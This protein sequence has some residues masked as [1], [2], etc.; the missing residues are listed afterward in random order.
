MCRCSPQPGGQ[1]GPNMAANPIELGPSQPL[2]LD[3]EKSGDEAM[4]YCY[5]KL[6]AKSAELFG[7]K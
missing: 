3:V 7:T 6:N 4:V 2:S 5:G 1:G